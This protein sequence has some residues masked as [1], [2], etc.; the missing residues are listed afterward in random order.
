MKELGKAPPQ[1]MLTRNGLFMD[2]HAIY[3]INDITTQIL[4]LLFVIHK[5]GVRYTSTH[6]PWEIHMIPIE[7]HFKTYESIMQTFNS[8][9]M[10][11]NLL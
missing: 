11:E 10:N 2:I 7:N 6:E 1:V 3:Q 4:L 9:Q 5:K 8:P